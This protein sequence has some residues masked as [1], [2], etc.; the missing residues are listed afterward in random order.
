[1]SNTPTHVP[2]LEGFSVQIVEQ[3]KIPMGEV[4]RG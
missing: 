4:V 3:V 2:A 1:L